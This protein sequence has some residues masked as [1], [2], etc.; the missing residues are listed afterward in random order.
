MQGGDSAAC[1]MLWLQS[2]ALLQP[3][4]PAAS[5]QP[6]EFASVE[7]A[8]QL[9]LRLLAASTQPS[10]LELLS[11]LLTGVWQDGAAF[12]DGKVGAAPLRH[13]CCR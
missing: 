5:M 7:S 2:L 1:L 6:T 10:Q 9:F 11:Q 3:G 12:P 8:Q 13:S 4:W